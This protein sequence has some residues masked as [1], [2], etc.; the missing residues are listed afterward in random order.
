MSDATHPI[1]AEADG[2]AIPV[3]PLTEAEVEGFLAQKRGPVRVFATANK[4]TGKAGQVLAVPGSSGAVERVLSGPI[5]STATRRAARAAP[6]C[7]CPGKGADLGEARAVAHAC[8][9]ARDMVN[10][11]AADMGPLQIETIAR[12]IARSTAR[13]ARSPATT[14][15]RPTIRPSTPSAAPPCPQRQPRDDRDRLESGDRPAAGRPRRQGGGVRHRRPRLKPSAGMRLMKKDMGGAAH[16][17][18][19]ARMVMAAGLPVR[20][21]VLVPAV[22]NAISATPCARATCCR[23]A[24]A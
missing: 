20:L 10:T 16:A 15:W 12:E 5:A 22:E 23:P 13:P 18:A 1:L 6:A 7:S 14:C 3:H 24:R 9:L 21:V 19:L 2:Q 17:L 4:F 8:A 11:P